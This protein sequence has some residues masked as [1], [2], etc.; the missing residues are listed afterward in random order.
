MIFNPGTLNRKIK[1]IGKVQSK[2]E[3]GFDTV[4]DGV[5]Y[6]TWA[7]IA[8]VRGKEYYDSDRLR[9]NNYVTITIR[10]RKNVTDQMYVIYEDHR[11]NIE[12][13]V[14]PY[15]THESLELYCS[16]DTRGEH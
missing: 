6:E 3:Y 1:I 13:V 2:D 10:Y 12:N 5:I 7:K 9:D 11:Y 14:D 16:E 4:K 15:M 8:P